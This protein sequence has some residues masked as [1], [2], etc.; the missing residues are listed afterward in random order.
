M[1]FLDDEDKEMYKQSIAAR[2]KRLIAE[3]KGV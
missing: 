2:L 3:R 1:S